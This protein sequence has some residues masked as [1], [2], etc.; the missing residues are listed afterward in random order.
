MREFYPSK[1]LLAGEYSVLLG[2]RALAL[3]F[4]EK[5]SS[6]SQSKQL[7]EPILLPYL[8]QYAENPIWSELIDQKQ[9]DTDLKAGWTLETNIPLGYGLGSSGALCA[10]I[11]DKYSRQRSWTQEKLR[12]QLQQMESL[13]HR[14]SSGIDPLISFLQKPLIMDGDRISELDSSYLTHLNNYPIHLVDSKKPR[15]TSEFVQK[16]RDKITDGKYESRI[17]NELIPLN[18]RM[19]SHFVSNQTKEFRNIWVQIS[20]LSLE[21]FAEMIPPDIEL[22]W[23]RGLE[24]GRFALKLCGAGGGGYFLMLGESD[25]KELNVLRPNFW[26]GKS[27]EETI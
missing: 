24:N 22:F 3:P 7:D 4:F 18:N 1:I 13:F 5:R 19:I 11:I 27:S 25:R 21:L 9:M 2:S 16:F 12:S 10:A 23:R 17:K 15:Q 8:K 6:W 20:E 14:T 26:N